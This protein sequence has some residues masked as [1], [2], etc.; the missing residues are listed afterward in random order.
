M[1]QRSNT[2]KAAGLYTYLSELN[3]PEGSQVVA[4]NVNIDEL[5]VIT[6][7]RGF[8]DYGNALPSSTFRVKQILEYKN[9]IIRHYNN[10]LQF[11]D[12]SG[13]FSTFS[14][15]FEEVEPGFRIKSKEINGNYYFTSSDGIKKI[16]ATSS[17]QF[18]T[19]AGYV[20]DAGAPKAIDLNG[21]TLPNDSG[22]LPPQSKVAYKVL[23]GYKDTNNVLILGTP[24]SRFVVTNNST[25][26]NIPESTNVEFKTTGTNFIGNYFTVD[27]VNNSYYVW[28]SDAAGS[29]AEPQDSITIGRTGIE[30]SILSADTAQEVAEKTANVLF[31][32]LANEFTITINTATIKFVSKES[33]DVSDITNGNITSPTDIEVTVLQQGEVSQGKNANCEITT[34]IPEGVT[35][36]YFIQLYRTSVITVTEGLTLNDIDPGEDCNLV[37]E[38]AITGSPGDTITIEDITPNDFRDTGTP[39]YNNPISGEGLL[40]T[41]DQPPISK[42][43]ELFNGFTFYSNTKSFHRYQFSIVSVDDFGNLETDFVIANEDGQRTYTFAGTQEEVE[44]TCDTVAN[45]NET[46]GANPNSYITL[47]SANDERKYYIWFDKGSG[48]DPLVEN[49]TGIKV[50]LS[51]AGIS[52]SDNVAQYLELA[53]LD[54][55][56]FNISATATTVT[57][58]NI[59]N[60][61]S[62]DADTPTSDPATDIGGVWAINVTDGSGED[63]ANNYALWSILPSVGQSIEET[64]RSLV[65]VI[66]KDVN[67]PVKATYL[68]GQNDL[69]G[70]IL[71]ENRQLEDKPFY[72]SVRNSGSIGNNIGGE[73]NPELP[74]IND[75]VVSIDSAP[76]DA[77]VTRVES[78]AHGLSTGDEVYLYAP[79]NTPAINNK[80]TITVFDV[81]NFDVNF[82]TTSGDS[83][84][85]FFFLAQEESD[86]LTSPNRLYYSKLQRPEAVPFVNYVDV[87]SKDEPIERILALRDTLFILKTDG[88]YTLTGFAAPFSVRL[89]DSTST[90]IAPDSARLLGN[91]IYSLM[92][93]G[94]STITES[95]VT[96]IS[97]SIENQIQAAT[98]TS[99]DYRLK[100]FGV[101]YESDKAYILWL[102]QKS[103]DETATQAFR[104]NYFEKTWTRWTT[105]ATS[106]RASNNQLLYIGSGDRE[107]MQRERKNRNRTDFSDRNFTLQ[108]PNNS[109]ENS[110]VNLSSYTE[111]EI[112]DVLVQNQ[113][114]T[115]DKFN[116]L[117]VKLDIDPGLILS[118]YESRF[119][120][121]AGDNIAQAVED[122]NSGLISDGVTV[123][124]RGP[125]SNSD[126]EDLKDKYNLLIGDLNAEICET[127][128]KNYNLIENIT[129]Y[130]SIVIDKNILRPYKN[131]IT[132]LIEPRFF[133]GDVEVF[134]AIKTEIQWNPLHFGDP[135]AQK[136]FSRGTIIL[137]QNNFTQATVSYSSDL[138]QGFVP[139]VKKGKGVGYWSSGNWGDTDLYW[140]GN[141][142]DVPIMSIIPREKQRGRYLNVKFEHSIAR[143]SFRILGVTSV[144]RV[145][146]ARA[147]R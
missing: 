136:Q 119:K 22:F 29:T 16:S 60:G 54:F 24:T 15:S 134:K 95:G 59:N 63:S 135:S 77:T 5:G 33:G 17:S 79:N 128:Y 58:Q 114:I 139:I 111:V 141:G 44:I 38:E 46:N 76:L 92:D 3:A 112:G 145:V 62:T 144:I 100:T 36:D 42:D 82:T 132:T 127:L 94:V 75:T 109:V 86:N 61:A 6:P 140:G 4:D 116:N 9:R 20:V 73:F 81:N 93:D 51:A 91:Q 7:R 130:E 108:I 117:L 107:Y 110:K 21:K 13:N 35:T 30:V 131:E 74:V 115:V 67:S 105:S 19:A 104:Y 14:G 65:R 52:A 8:S 48:E 23:F 96:L 11:D 125:F 84:D 68:S 137:D 113:Y 2:I 55:D 1:S 12:G 72:I 43:I 41:N 123:V 102:P 49:A 32:E 103:E 69:P 31:S 37:Y 66:N 99:I 142:N 64:A 87:G 97:R 147:Y 124:Y 28:Y 143:E 83:T 88:V 89:L 138:S 27:A 98:D 57:V 146:S 106:G 133:E 45:T 56:D 53:L 18:T 85:A 122:L 26:I 118:N 120:V 40:Q 71:F 10:V 126:W 121:K 70:K 80:Y 34:V 101:S 25:D 47:Y 90:I 50:E 129:S 78:T 39:L